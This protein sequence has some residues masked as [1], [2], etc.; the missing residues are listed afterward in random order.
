MSYSQY[1]KIN[2]PQP[3]QTPHIFLHR[4]NISGV[5]TRSD[6]YYHDIRRIENLEN[7]KLLVSFKRSQ[8]IVLGFHCLM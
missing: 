3:P 2:G 5:K 7:L 6:L 8:A 1:I 4:I